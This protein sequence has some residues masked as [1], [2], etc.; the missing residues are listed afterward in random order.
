MTKFDKCQKCCPVDFDFL[1]MLY[2]NIINWAFSYTLTIRHLIWSNKRLFIAYKKKQDAVYVVNWQLSMICSKGILESLRRRA[3]IMTDGFNSCRNVVCNFT[4]GINDSVPN[5]FY[6]F[7]CCNFILWLPLFLI[8]HWVI[9][10]VLFRCHVFIPSNKIATKS[11]RG[12]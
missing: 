6:V 4:E 12:C 9:S 11:Y 1:C 7:S 8:N 5:E 2:S 10:W 3:R